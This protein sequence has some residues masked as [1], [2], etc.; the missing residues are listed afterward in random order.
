M[1]TETDLDSVTLDPDPVTTAIGATATTTHIGVDQGHSTGLP[2]T[3]SHMIE[4]PAPTTTIMT[5]PTA[6]HS[7]NRNA[8]RDNSKSCHRSGKHHYRLA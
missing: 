7:T 5:H 2:A 6:R 1:N 3:I 8:S 4:A